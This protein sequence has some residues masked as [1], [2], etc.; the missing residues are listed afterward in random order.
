MEAEPGNSGPPAF[1]PV[2]AGVGVPLF[3]AA[4]L[5]ALGIVVA[6]AIWLRPAY[7]LIA[8]IPLG[9]LC[10]IAA[11]RA[12]RIAWLPLA[13]L[14]CLLGAWC[15]EMQPQP[16][17]APALAA[18]SDGLVRTVE[19]TVIDAGPVRGELEQNVEEADGHCTNAARR[20]AD[21]KR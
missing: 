19:G 9:I 12:Q 15:A 14:W 18:L 7:L 11:L 6:H 10:G 8:L 5:F 1:R 2:W 3:H 13:A 20:P 16:A 21:L 17:P 4:W